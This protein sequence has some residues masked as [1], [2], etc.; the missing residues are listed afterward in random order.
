MW[1]CDAGDN[2]GLPPPAPVPFRTMHYAHTAEAA[3]WAAI[4]RDGAVRRLEGPPR[5][6]RS[7]PC[8]RSE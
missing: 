2:D 4:A 1:E 7:G 8:E 3:D 6:A 5:E